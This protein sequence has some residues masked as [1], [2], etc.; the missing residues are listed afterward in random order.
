MKLTINLRGVQLI[1]VVLKLVGVISW[2]WWV[3]LIPLELELWFV[4]AVLLY[5]GCNRRRRR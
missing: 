3:V 2:S 4:L 1:L 5:M